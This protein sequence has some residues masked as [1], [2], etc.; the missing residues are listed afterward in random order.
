MC[1]VNVASHG[2]LEGRLPMLWVP[3]ISFRQGAGVCICVST[4]PVSIFCSSLM[5]CVYVV[6]VA[7]IADIANVADSVLFHAVLMS[8]VFVCI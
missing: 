7:D 4:P 1:N 5:N 6:V 3:P 8:F 2:L